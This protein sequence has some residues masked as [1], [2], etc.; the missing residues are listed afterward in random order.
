MVNRDKRHSKFPTVTCVTWMYLFGDAVTV[1][2]LYRSLLQ[3]GV[4]IVCIIMPLNFMFLFSFSIC[5]MRF[6]L[7]IFIIAPVKYYMIITGTSSMLDMRVNSKTYDDKDFHP[8]PKRSGQITLSFRN[9]GVSE[10]VHCTMH[11]FFYSSCACASA[12]TFSSSYVWT[13]RMSCVALHLVSLHGLL[14]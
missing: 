10:G 2:L 13:V 6:W 9:L 4:D 7:Y 11:F 12:W 5:R 3:S 14:R 8:N 1:T